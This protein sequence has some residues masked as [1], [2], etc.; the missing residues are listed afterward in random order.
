MALEYEPNDYFESN[1]L[2]LFFVLTM[3]RPRADND[4]THL[5]KLGGK[6][7]PDSLTQLTKETGLLLAKTLLTDKPFDRPLQQTVHP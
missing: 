5:N 3:M 4:E 2:F 7:L 1:T 6:L